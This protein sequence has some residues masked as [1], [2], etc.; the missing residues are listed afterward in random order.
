M[1]RHR[2]RP[3]RTG[4]PNQAGAGAARWSSVCRARP[5]RSEGRDHTTDHAARRVVSQPIKRFQPPAQPDFAAPA[6]SPPS[7]Q[8]QARSTARQRSRHHGHQAR[9]GGLEPPTSGL[10]GR[11]SIQL[12]Y[13]RFINNLTPLTSTPQ[14]HRY[15]R[16]QHA[17]LARASSRGAG[18]EHR[19]LDGQS[20]AGL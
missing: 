8:H 1:S 14:Q 3:I 5:D 16:S 12:S 19:S 6:T 11:R 18:R 10:E 15:T 17:C 7:N 20:P 2:I 9:A 13:A 4:E